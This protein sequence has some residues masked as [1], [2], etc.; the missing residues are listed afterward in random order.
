MS[1]IDMI[2]PSTMTPAIL[3]TAASSLV[4]AAAAAGWLTTSPPTCG[5]L[6]VLTDELP[7][8]YLVRVWAGEPVPDVLRRCSSSRTGKVTLSFAGERHGPPQ[9]QAT[10]RGDDAAERRRRVPQ[11]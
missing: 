9:H 7:T 6:E 11:R 4:A 8:H 2:A 1:R 5:C 10:R 3:R